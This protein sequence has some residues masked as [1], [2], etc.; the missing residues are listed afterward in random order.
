M[1]DKIELPDSISSIINEP[2]DGTDKKLALLE[3]LATLAE[4]QAALAAADLNKEENSA[5]FDRLSEMRRLCIEQIDIIDEQLTGQAY[6]PEKVAVLQTILTR[7]QAFDQKTA[8]IIGKETADIK[9]QLQDLANNKK[10][11]L[12]Y[13]T[14]ILAR[15]SM[16]ID[17]S[18]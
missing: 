8:D 1:T 6:S 2:S 5:G 3:Q 12:T 15:K 10:N 14:N 16:I 13:H 17:K 11:M 7:I 18:R 9:N 4:E